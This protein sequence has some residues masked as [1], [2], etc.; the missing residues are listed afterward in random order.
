MTEKADDRG[1][2]C[3]PH[4]NLCDREEQILFDHANPK[5]S[6]PPPDYNSPQS[7]DALRSMHELVNQRIR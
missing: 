3:E 1:K 4:R 6:E 5:R 2:T 7:G